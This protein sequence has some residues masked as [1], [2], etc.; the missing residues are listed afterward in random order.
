MT[1]REVML[2]NIRRVARRLGPLR[3]KV[4]FLGG[5]VVALL[6]TDPGAPDVRPTKDVDVAYPTASF[7]ESASLDETLRGLDFKHCKDP[8]APTCRWVVDD[9]LVDVMAVGESVNTYRDRWS[10]AA[11]EHSES[12]E[13]EEGLRIRHVTAPYFIA[14]KLET[15]E[16]RGDEDYGGSR[17]M[18]DI[19]QII[20]SRPEL[21][22]EIR[23]S[24]S[25][26]CLYIS[27]KLGALLE[28]DRF[29]D[30][31]SAHLLPDAASQAREPLLRSRIA[32]IA[33]L[34]MN[35]P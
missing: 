20:D 16:D 5:S 28:N 17:D 3:E 34:H 15:F 35:E 33:S 25:D 2:E 24:A 29:L 6:I 11:I 23:A 19:L 32:Q 22:G 21:R 31:L 12:L 30:S 14:I 1:D 9:L 13:V 26:L 4:V 27:E 10:L 7:S 8:G 18:E